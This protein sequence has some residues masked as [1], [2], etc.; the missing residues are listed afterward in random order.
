L[1]LN[2]IKQKEIETMKKDE[3]FRQLCVWPGTLLGESTVEDFEQFFLEDMG[4]RV[5]FLEEVVTNPDVDEYGNDIED[6]GGRNDLF[7]YVHSEDC[8]KFAIPRLRM[9]IKWWEDVVGNDNHKIYP[10]EVLTKN[11]ILW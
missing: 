10:T 2:P 1:L 6:T 11:P 9:G 4:V 5:K 3:N 8:G 7:F